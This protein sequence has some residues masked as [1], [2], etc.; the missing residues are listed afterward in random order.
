MTTRRATLFDLLRAGAEGDPALIAPGGPVWTFADLRA[1]VGQLAEWLQA[2]GLGRGDR[3]AIA[4]GNG[5]AMAIAFLA[6]A[7]AATAAP[8]NPKYR[9]DE[10][11]FYYEDTNAR[12]LIVAPGEGDEARAALRLGMLLIEATLD[13]DGR[14]VFSAAGEASPPRHDGWADADDVAMILHTSGT[15]SRPK[16]VPIRHRNL[17][18]STANIIATYQLSPADRSLCVMPLF[19]IHGIVASLLSQLAAGG[20]VI[21][22]PGFDGLKFWSWVEQAWP[23]WYSAVPTMHQVLLARAERNAAIIAANPFR[24]IR[25]SSAP[26]PPVV[27]ERMEAVFGAPVI[28]SYG[29]TEASHQM[30][31]NPLPPGQ[32][33]PGSVGIGFG[34]EVGIM[35]ENGNLLPAGVKGEVVVRGPNVVDGYENNPEAN[36]AAFVDGWF[37][38]G[39]QGYLDDDGYLC[40][41]GRIKE[42]INRGGEKISPLEID[43]VL[44]RHPAVAE[45]LAFAAPHPTLGEEVHAAVVLREGIQASERELRDHCAQ[46]LADFKVPRV[47][48]ILS[49][50]PRGATGKL[51]RITMAKTL[52]LA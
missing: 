41:T 12:A 33:K 24:F 15:T 46:W 39:D 9:R 18:A 7:T 48:H 6:A 37:R 47:I 30:T 38:T 19:H 2:H 51:Q 17:V 3:I 1:Q 44:L 34:V 14:L 21:C 20:A 25:S 42:L 10:F 8:L 28:E 35:D 49:A 45:A 4:L 23:T 26:L 40:L 52:G 43:D 11:A 5:P 31:S 29:M 32:R 13:T 16:R 50:L 22:P 36:A 27:M